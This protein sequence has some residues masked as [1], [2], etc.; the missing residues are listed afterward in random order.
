MT[1]LLFH[2]GN[3]VIFV[4]WLDFCCSSPDVISAGHKGLMPIAPLVRVTWALGFGPWNVSLN[5]GSSMSCPTTQCLDEEV[6]WNWD[7]RRLVESWNLHGI[8][9]DW[10]LKST[11]ELE[12]CL[13]LFGITALSSKS[14]NTRY[15]FGISEIQGGEKKHLKIFGSQLHGNWGEF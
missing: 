11:I 1:R 7:L 6:S 12:L 15:C 9:H 8:F 5:C 2:L 4:F 14:S 13:V 3:F 10:N